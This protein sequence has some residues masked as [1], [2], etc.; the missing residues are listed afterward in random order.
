MKRLTAEEELENWQRWLAAE[1][2]PHSLQTA[3][4][5]R[6]CVHAVAALRGRI[7]SAQRALLLEPDEP[8]LA[9][10]GRP[11]APVGRHPSRTANTKHMEESPE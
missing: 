8:A 7:D 11:W 9:V 2:M 5:V 1:T 3:T 4:W 6:T 10:S